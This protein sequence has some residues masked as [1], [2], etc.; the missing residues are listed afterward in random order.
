MTSAAVALGCVPLPF[1]LSVFSI[2]GYRLP[3]LIHKYVN[4]QKQ[5]CPLFSEFVVPVIDPA[6]DG[7]D[8]RGLKCRYATRT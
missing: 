7:Y 2:L 1:P 5:A 3:D 6:V 8:L 4:K